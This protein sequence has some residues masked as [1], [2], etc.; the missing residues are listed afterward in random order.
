MLTALM[1]LLLF[2]TTHSPAQSRIGSDRTDTIAGELRII[3]VNDRETEIKLGDRI[4]LRTLKRKFPRWSDLYDLSI[5]DVIRHRM[6]PFDQVVIL[7]NWAPNHTGCRPG[8]FFLGLKKDGTFR[9]SKSTPNCI[10]RE[11][12]TRKDRVVI[13]AVPEVSTTEYSYLPIPGG[14]WLY[15]NGVLHT[16]KLIILPDTRPRRRRLTNR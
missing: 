14:K 16:V 12:E 15:Q 8:V 1:F 9:F 10:E 3:L 2:S 13:K 6:T 5:Y 11:I 4:I 7:N